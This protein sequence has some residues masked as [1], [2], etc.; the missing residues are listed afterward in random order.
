MFVGRL[1][2]YGTERYWHC[3]IL[4]GGAVIFELVC[5]SKEDISSKRCE[6]INNLLNSN[7]S[8]SIS[9]KLCKIC[10]ILKSRICGNCGFFIRV[11][12]KMLCEFCFKFN[13]LSSSEKILKIGRDLTKEIWQSYCQS[14]VAPCFWDTV[15]LKAYLKVVFCLLLVIF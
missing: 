9:L 7:V 6:N 15:Y 1:A 10:V 4:T 8:T 5:G 3:N 13:S 12:V 2:R 11:E 14:S